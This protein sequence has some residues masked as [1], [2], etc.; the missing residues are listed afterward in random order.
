MG[1]RRRTARAALAA[2][3]GGG[4]TAVGLGGT[5]PNRALGVGVP[6]S[7]P[8][9]TDGSAATLPASDAGD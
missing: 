1:L 9:S 8:T 7:T 5:L 4:L 6:A 2:L 3:A